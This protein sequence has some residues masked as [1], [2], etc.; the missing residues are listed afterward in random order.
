MDD[1][2]VKGGGAP[3]DCNAAAPHT[4][5]TASLHPL[6]LTP[7]PPP[8]STPSSSLHPLLLTPPP[9]PHSTPS[10]SLHPLLTP[11][12][13]LP[14]THSIPSSPQTHSICSSYPLHLTPSPYPSSSPPPYWMG[15]L[16]LFTAYSP[17]SV[18]LRTW[19]TTPKPPFPS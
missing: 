1:L 16:I 14:Q 6:L 13:A 15:S 8:H 4:A 3:G 18:L 10:S 12:P 19:Y 2:Q 9:P 5:H 17:P 7:P 11:S